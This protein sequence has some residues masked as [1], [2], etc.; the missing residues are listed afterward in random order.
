MVSASFSGDGRRIGTASED[1]AARIWD[2][3]HTEAILGERA[4]VL[5][6]AL[7]QGIGWRTRGETND[8]LMQDAPEDMFADALPKLGDRNGKVEEVAA[9]RRAPLH[10]NCY[11]SPTQLAEKFGTTPAREPGLQASD[12]DTETLEG[13]GLRIV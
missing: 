5:T 13:F 6:A 9:A 8:L 3:S 4:I 11:L 1:K 2:V 12:S 10:D 7:A